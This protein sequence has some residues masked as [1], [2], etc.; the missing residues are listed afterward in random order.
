MYTQ[1]DAHSL[2]PLFVQGATV[3]SPINWGSSPF[4]D[5]GRFGALSIVEI[6]EGVKKVLKMHV[7]KRF[8]YE[9]F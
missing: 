3:I 1:K 6:K 5:S 2:R 4:H 9:T 7:S 8:P